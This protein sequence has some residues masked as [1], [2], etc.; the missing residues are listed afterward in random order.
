MTHYAPHALDLASCD[1]VLRAIAQEIDAIRG[2]G[3]RG[4][5]VLLKLDH[6]GE[7]TIRTRLPGIRGLAIRFAGVD[8][9]ETAVPVT[10][11]V[12]YR[13]PIRVHPVCL[14]TTACPSF[15]WNPERYL[16][17]A[18]LLRL[19]LHRRQPRPGHG[20]AT[21]LPGRPLSAVPLPRHHELCRGCPKGL[22]PTAAI[23]TIKAMLV[24]RTL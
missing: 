3:K 9:V 22:N 21:G 10:P 18:A 16:G 24:N 1:V 7:E 14:L 6:L 20:G 8:P 15:W 13:W 5:H 4:D 11:A 23:G 2:C 12:H 17:P 19:A